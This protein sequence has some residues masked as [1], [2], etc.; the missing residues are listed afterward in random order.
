[1]GDTLQALGQALSSSYRVE[2]EIGEGG[3]A[4][5]FLATDLKHQRPVAIQVLRPELALSLGPERFLRE[6][7][8][9]A[10]L[11][12]PK[13]LPSTIRARPRGC[14]TTSCP[15]WKGNPSGT[16]SCAAARFRQARRRASRAR[17]P[18]RSTWG[19]AETTLQPMVDRAREAVASL[20]GDA[21]PV[22]PP[23]PS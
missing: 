13:I 4:T 21:R 16:G 20:R 12:H 3:M 8:I 7:E 18:T 5:V 2:R 23:P 19:R 6:I 22:T 11:Q 15:S 17:S 9:A 14:C 1:M 10:R